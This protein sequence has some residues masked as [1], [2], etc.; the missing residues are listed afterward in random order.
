M[1]NSSINVSTPSLSSVFNDG[2]GDSGKSVNATL[3]RILD[4]IGD[5]MVATHSQMPNNSNSDALR[6][7]T[8]NPSKRKSP[9]TA[10]QSPNINKRIDL[11]PDILQFFHILTE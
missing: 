1:S 9:K 5:L 11:N 8:R 10:S 7:S 6:K 2:D 3:N 4:R